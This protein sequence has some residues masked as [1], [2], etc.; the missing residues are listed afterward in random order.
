MGCFPELEPWN[1]TI[2]EAFVMKELTSKIYQY[3]KYN[4]GCLQKELK[5]AIGVEDGRLVTRVVY[6]MALVGKLERR[7]LRHTYSLDVK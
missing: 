4:E 1:N 2:E 3:V 5:K 6:Y 7:K